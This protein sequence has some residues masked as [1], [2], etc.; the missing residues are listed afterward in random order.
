M[1]NIRIS[2]RGSGGRLRGAVALCAMLGAGYVASGCQSMLSL[3]RRG[4][5][6][7]PAQEAQIGL[8]AYQEWSNAHEPVKDQRQVEVVRRVEPD[9]RALRD[10]R[11]G[12]GKR[13]GGDGEQRVV[14]LHRHSPRRFVRAYSTAAQMFRRV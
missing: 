4:D 6:L 8:L 3:T 5:A 12:R 9:V 13:E 2:H 11:C 1:T 14:D 10:G 7:S